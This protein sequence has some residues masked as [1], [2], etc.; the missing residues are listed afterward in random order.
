MP[1]LDPV[2]ICLI[3]CGKLKLERKAK[4]KDLYIG[5]LFRAARGFAESCDDWRILS[6]KHGLLDP[7]KVISPYNHRL[8][9]R[10]Y[11]RESWGIKTASELVSQMEDIKFEVIILAGADYAEFVTAHLERHHVKVRNPLLGMG[12]GQRLQWLKKEREA[13]LISGHCPAAAVH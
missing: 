10:E 12:L 11:D 5:S 7:E 9:G 13:D 8:P 2:T 6:A 3:G 4:A 1:E